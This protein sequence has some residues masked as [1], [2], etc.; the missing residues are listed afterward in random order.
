MRKSDILRRLEE[1]LARGEIGEK[2]Y[3][4]IKARYDTEPE[5]LPEF[6]PE[7][8]K[9][10]AETGRG[11]EDASQA[12]E[13]FA[14]SLE[15]T[16][17]E[18]IEPVIRNIPEIERKIKESVEPALRNIDFAE[19]G[20][21]V[22]TS[23]GSV[24]IAG[25]GV[26]TGNPLRTREFKTAGSGRVVGDLEAFEAK[27]AGSCVFEGNVTVQ[28]FKSAG[29]SKVAGVLRARELHSSGSLSVGKGI[30]GQEVHIRGSLRLDGNLKAHEAHLAGSARISGVL[31]AQETRIE[32]G[33]EVSIPVV[34]S[35]EIAVRRPGGF[36]RGACEMISDRIEGEDVYL[37]CTTAK[38]VRGREVSIGPHCRIDVVEAG[39]L[40][41][42]ESA[43]V[44]ERRPLARK[45]HEEHAEHAG[46]P[47]GGE[48][49]AP[50]EPPTLP[51]AP[52]A[53]PGPG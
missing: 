52:D 19:F 28:E 51:E 20:R 25:S 27:V 15:R 30:D 48:P 13:A 6:P 50:P 18:A 23:E 3:L 17:R 46:H 42:H 12:A 34:K 39:E 49:P 16:I 36:F 2:T 4:E 44:R 22:Q 31:E 14:R 21:T 5:E 47:P 1:R 32:L 10:S 53:P 11:A 37:E 29:S 7:E 40:R 38:Y 9:V 35:R 41:V 26:V 45:V 8:A 33:G 24:K 43:E